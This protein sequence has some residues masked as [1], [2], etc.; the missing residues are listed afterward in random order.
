M[1]YQT[2]CCVFQVST[3]CSYTCRYCFIDTANN[4]SVFCCCFAVNVITMYL[5][6]DIL[7][8]KCVIKYVFDLKRQ[9]KLILVSV[10]LY[11]NVCWEGIYQIFLPNNSF[12]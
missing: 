11:K 4:V 1:H 10:F 3:D 2:V 9:V 7:M 5:F 8:S 6:A 12:K